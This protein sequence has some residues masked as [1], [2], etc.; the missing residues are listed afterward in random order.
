M[1]ARFVLHLW[2]DSGPSKRVEVPRTVK[3]LKGAKQ[4]A[5][6]WAADV[7]ASGTISVIAEEK[8]Q[9]TT[10]SGTVAVA[11]VLNSRITKWE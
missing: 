7:G 4:H 3:A 5:S 9:T 6:Q 11:T 1:T 8:G 2:P 10:V